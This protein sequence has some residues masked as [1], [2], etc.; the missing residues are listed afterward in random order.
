MRAKRTIAMWNPPIVDEKTAARR[1][2]LA[3]AADLLSDNPAALRL[4]YLQTLADVG[5][6]QG[7]TVL[8]PLPLDVI[9]SVA[10]AVGHN[11]R[12]NGTGV[13]QVD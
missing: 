11:G 8:L 2:V 1:S 4:R 12:G 9:G 7:S 3:E 13:V 5:K 10:R 6:G